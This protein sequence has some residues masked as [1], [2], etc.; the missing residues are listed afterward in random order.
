MSR[1][2]S[3]HGCM[4]LTKQYPPRPAVVIS[5]ECRRFVGRSATSDLDIE[6]E[7]STACKQD[8]ADGSASDRAGYGHCAAGCCRSSSIC[9]RGDG[10]LRHEGAA[11]ATGRQHSKTRPMGSPVADSDS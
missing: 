2:K 5:Q 9:F 7:T 4:E 6:S 11:Y 10:Q 3:C 1:G 8:I